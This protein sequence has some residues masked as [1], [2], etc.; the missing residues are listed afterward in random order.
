VDSQARV[1]GD[2]QRRAF[3]NDETADVEKL[4]LLLDLKAI[5]P[6][7]ATVFVREFF[8]WRQLRNRREVSSLAGLTPSPNDSGGTRREQGIS[9]AGNRRLRLCIE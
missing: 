1:L 9:E 5:G 4:R 6:H 7:G 8:G 2:A 3:R